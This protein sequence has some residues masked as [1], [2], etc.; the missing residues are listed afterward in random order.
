MLREQIEDAGKNQGGK[1]EH[2]NPGLTVL[3][4]AAAAVGRTQSLSL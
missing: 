1:A 2:R 4:G 3:K